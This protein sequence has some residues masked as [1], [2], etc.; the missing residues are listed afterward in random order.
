MLRRIKDKEVAIDIL[1]GVG[2]PS[3][4]PLLSGTINWSMPKLKFPIS[5]SKVK[6]HKTINRIFKTNTIVVF[7]FC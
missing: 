1:P 3:I 6:V 4:C 7:T 2:F 5:C